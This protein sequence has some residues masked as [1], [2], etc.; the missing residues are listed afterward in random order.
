MDPVVKIFSTPM[1]LAE[2]FAGEFAAMVNEAA[3]MKRPFRVAL[4]GGTTPKLLFTIL[5]TRYVDSISWDHVHFF[6]G[7]ERC[8]SPDD[9]ESNYGMT[10][11]VLLGKIKIPEINIHRIM[12]ENDPYNEAGRYSDEISAFTVSR[13]G[14][15]SFDLILLGLGDDGHT[16][17]IF[18]G[19]NSLFQSEKIGEAVVHPKSH[20]GR[21][22]I[23]GKVIN[24]AERIVF[25]VTGENK[26][27]V[28]SGIL[29]NMEKTHYPAA[30]VRPVSGT[31]K[32]YL[33]EKAASLLDL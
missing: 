26:A 17:S 9:P 14:W 32:W 15:P 8:V 1:D 13:N 29:K 21:V 4:S 18:P 30:Q 16:A 3:F 22:T 19:N 27:P 2:G 33:D 31:I 5:G 11:S 12:G 6:W 28:V 10:R 7:D 20:Q 23:T 25:L 24:N